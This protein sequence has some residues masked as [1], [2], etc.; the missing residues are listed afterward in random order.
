M[1]TPDQEFETDC[2][3]PRAGSC[4]GSRV[5]LLTTAA[6]NRKHTASPRS[7]F[8][9]LR[10]WGGRTRTRKCRF[11]PARSASV[12]SRRPRKVSGTK[13]F[14]RTKEFGRHSIK[15]TFASSSPLTPATQSVRS[16]GA[17]A[18]FAQS[19]ATRRSSPSLHCPRRCPNGS[20]NRRRRDRSS[21]AGIA[22]CCIGCRDRSDAAAHRACLV[23]RLP[24]PKHR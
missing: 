1:L 20:S 3:K 9:S 6:R 23:A 13:I 5:S 8:G 4:G 2:V 12:S 21:T 11:N 22:R 7:E 18:L 19:S 17:C 14:W 10:G 15:P 16:Q 24:S